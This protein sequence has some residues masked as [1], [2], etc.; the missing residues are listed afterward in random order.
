VEAN[1]ANKIFSKHTAGPVE[2]LRLAR[3]TVSL[4]L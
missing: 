4:L 3:T 2:G 1:L